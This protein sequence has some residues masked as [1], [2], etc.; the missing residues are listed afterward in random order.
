MK[1]TPLPPAERLHELLIYDAEEGTLTWRERPL[2]EFLG[3]KYAPARLAKI[4]NSKFAGKPALAS[5]MSNGYQHG[6]IDSAYYL[7]HRIAWKMATGQEP[8]EI[9]HI[10]GDRTDN[11]I[12]NLRSGARTTN[13]RNRG[14]S[15][16]NTSGATGVCLDQKSGH[17]YAQISFGD[18]VRTSHGFASFDDAVAVRKEWERELGFHPNHGERPGHRMAAAS[19]LS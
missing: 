7:R 9:D 15:S 13:M 3:F 12:A 6:T 17:W 10:N 16:N 8:E 14:V 19:F 4:W 18:E 11:R 2:S 5:K 1:R